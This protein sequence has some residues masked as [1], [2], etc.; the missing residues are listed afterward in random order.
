M[1][2]FLSLKKPL[3]VENYPDY[4]QEEISQY[5]EITEEEFMAIQQILG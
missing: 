5:V 2:S 4:S 3:T 1:T